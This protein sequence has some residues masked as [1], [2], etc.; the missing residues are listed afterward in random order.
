MVDFLRANPFISMEECKWK[1]NPA[2][3][4]LMN[5]DNTHIRCLSEEEVKMRNSINLSDVD[6]KNDFGVPIFDNN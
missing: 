2:L 3:V 5:I 4:K 6:I 1:I